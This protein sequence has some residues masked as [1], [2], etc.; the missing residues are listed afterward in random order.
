MCTA[1]CLVNRL[2]F[3]SFLSL[4]AYFSELNHSEPSCEP[5]DFPSV[6]GKLVFKVIHNAQFSLSLFFLEPKDLLS[7]G[8]PPPESDDEDDVI[9]TSTPMT[10][11]CGDSPLLDVFKLALFEGDM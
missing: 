6:F 8:H 10:F 9:M 7:E 3:I 11:D 2:S 1:F 4:I 5:W